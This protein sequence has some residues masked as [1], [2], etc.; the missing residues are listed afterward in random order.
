MPENRIH[1]NDV[2]LTRYVAYFDAVK[3]ERDWPNPWMPFFALKNETNA[4]WFLEPIPGREAALGLN[5][6][7]K[8]GDIVENF[9]FAYLSEEL[10]AALS[11][12]VDRDVLRDAL[13]YHWF[14]DHVD[15][16]TELVG[17]TRFENLLKTGHASEVRESPPA[18]SAAFRRL[19]VEAY[20]YRCAASGWRV[21]LPDYRVLVEAAHI[22]P[23]AET[24]DDRPQNGIA[25]TPNFHWALDRN[26]IAPGADLKWHVSPLIDKRIADNRPLVALDS[27][28][29]LLPRDERYHPD[30][31]ALRWRE[32][33]LLRG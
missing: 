8:R 12:P 28:P 2:L 20:E 18:R 15:A 16:L 17:V 10:F 21:I 27:Q 13:M 7:V 25:L 24:A 31:E 33:Q 1:F 11:N 26:I 30:R 9:E 23:F 4:F 3:G 19:V 29:L 5:S 6:A 22:V 32:A 14:P